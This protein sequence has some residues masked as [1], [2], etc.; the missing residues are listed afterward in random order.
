MMACEKPAIKL[1]LLSPRLPP[2]ATRNLHVPGQRFDSI[3]A[4]SAFCADVE[5]EARHY[6]K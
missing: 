3:V 6:I 2:P 4:V 1:D 5:P